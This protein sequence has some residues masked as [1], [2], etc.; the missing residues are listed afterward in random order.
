MVHTWWPMVC[1]IT[2]RKVSKYGVS[3][4]PYFSVFG[5][6]TDIYS[7]NVRIQSKYR[8]IRTRKHSVIGLNTPFRIMG[9]RVQNHWAALRSTQPFIL[10]KSIK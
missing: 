6:N 10:P 7:I 8:K 9:S 1:F 4:G 2:A 3:S 5:L